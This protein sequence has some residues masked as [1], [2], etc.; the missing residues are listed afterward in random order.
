MMSQE[1]LNALAMAYACEMAKADESCGIGGGDSFALGDLDG[2]VCIN[3]DYRAAI[4]S[5]GTPN[6]FSVSEGAL[7][8]GLSL[9]LGDGVISGIPDTAGAFTFE[10]SA[11]MANG[12][13]AKKVYT[14]GVVQIT[15]AALDSYTIGT[16]YSF[17]LQAV[18]GSGNYAWKVNTGTL[19]EG[20]TLSSTGLISG[21]PTAAGSDDIKFQVIDTTCESLNESYFTPGISLTTVA[22]TITRTRRGFPDYVTGATLYKRATYSGYITQIAYPQYNYDANDYI[23]CAGAKYEYGGYDEIDVFG[24]VTSRHTKVL[25]SMCSSSTPAVYLPVYNWSTNTYD[26]VGAS[27]LPVLLGYCWTD[28]PGS[29]PTCDADETTWNSEGNKA[30]F[31]RNDYPNLMA[32]PAIS[33]TA[34]TNSSSGTTNYGTL[35]LNRTGFPTNDAGG[36]FAANLGFFQVSATA[37]WSIVLSDEFTGAD[38]ISGQQV[39]IGAGKSTEN[40]PL[41][42]SW[43]FNSVY[44]E[45]SR[46]VTLDFTMSCSN[47]VAGRS[48]IASYEL[49]DSDGS[50]THHAATFTAAGTTYSVTGSVGIPASGHSATIKNIRINYI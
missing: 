45:Q 12:A 16:P 43:W 34:D 30:I 11:Y 47:L 22:T 38:A 42:R 33:G 13:I 2:C 17:Q 40:K 39:T 48:Y 24:N 37:D 1:A 20:L 8:P 29:C 21:T 32:G 46:L 19:P 18:G 9:N 49:W 25:S 35:V 26:L 6:L 15:T 31:G 3:E 23:Q 7:P 27:Y 44:N 4:S 41:S 50:H 5:S 36:V 28:D 14:I 10:I